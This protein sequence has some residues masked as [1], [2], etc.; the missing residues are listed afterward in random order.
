VNSHQQQGDASGVMSMIEKRKTDRINTLNLF[1]ILL[2]EEDTAVH[3]GMGRTLN[4]SETGI[5]LETYFPIEF[6][7]T[8]MISIGLAE[9]LVE[10]KGKVAHHRQLEDDK[11]VTGIYFAEVTDAAIQVI[12]KFVQEYGKHFS[13]DE[14]TP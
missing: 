5:L 7:H 14:P 11:F 4:L 9:D 6:E 3:Q 1:Y 8:V 13:A 10:I 2:N 12:Q